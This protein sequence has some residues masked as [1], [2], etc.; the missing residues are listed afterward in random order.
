M[1]KFSI[2]YWDSHYT[3]EKKIQWDIGYPSTPIKEYI[4]QL[5]D[6]NQ[7]ILVPGAGSGYEVEY[8]YNSGFKNVFFMDFAP[9]AVNRFKERN[10]TFPEDQILVEDFFEH[11][12][13]YNLIIEQT[14]FSSLPRSRR[15][16][17][18]QKLNELLVENAKFMGLLFNHEFNFADPPFGG[19]EAEYASLFR[20]CFNFIH[21]ETAYNSIKPRAGREI[22]LLLIKKICYDAK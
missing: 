14:F 6:K 7:K 1:K 19:T 8:L 11:Q 5:K 15:H 16:E 3:A 10:P 13:E 20:S 21:F 2:A 22:F 17:Y 4:D 9:S 18:V 12:G